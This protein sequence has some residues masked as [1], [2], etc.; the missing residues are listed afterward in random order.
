MVG[1]WPIEKPRM[2]AYAEKAAREAKVHTSW[3]DPVPAYEDAVRKFIEGMY[4]DSDFIAA[5]NEFVASLIHP[6]RINSLA[7]T[8]LKITAPGVPDF[9]QGT[10]LW[11]L[12]L[13]DPD[14]RRPQD[15]DLRRRMLADLRNA[16]PERVMERFDE[17]MP[18]LWLIRQALA[19]R[20]QH[21]EWFGPQAGIE[22]LE[23]RGA[24]RDHV[25]AFIRGE[26]VV[27]IVPRLVA[28]LGGDWRDTEVEL[29]RDEWTNH[30]TVVRLGG[31][32]TK[33][34]EL[35]QRFPVALLA[36]EGN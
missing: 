18:K 17:G 24:R 12:A 9:Y 23:V 22:P 8:L 26:S 30:M 21:P 19:L 27:T 14:N 29:P 35:M 33:L 32:R 20:K 3:T 4:D 1:A 11:N 31:G 36:R 34:A 28:K 13:V 15:F 7:Q 6:G 25:I 16:T 2:L 5:L 10:E